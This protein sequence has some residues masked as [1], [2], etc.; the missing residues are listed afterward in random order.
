MGLDKCLDELLREHAAETEY[1]R[2]YNSL[3]NHDIFSIEDF[4]RTEIA[5]MRQ[6]RNFG[7]KSIEAVQRMR[8][9]LAN[10]PEA[11]FNRLQ[12]AYTEASEG[13]QVLFREWLRSVESQKG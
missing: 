1:V 11:Q 6:Y 4:Q 10:R 13:A 7:R 12:S 8:D 2:L 3:C 9:A 5:E